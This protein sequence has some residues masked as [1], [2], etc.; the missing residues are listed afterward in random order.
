MEYAQHGGRIR[1]SQRFKTLSFGLFVLG[2]NGSRLA[3][4][5]PR[6]PATPA[7]PEQE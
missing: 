5:Q 7:T 6:L 1:L 4:F 2:L 3:S